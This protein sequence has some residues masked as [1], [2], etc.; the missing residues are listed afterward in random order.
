M[1]YDTFCFFNELELLEVRLNELDK[2]VDR[3]VLVEAKRSFSNHPK[4]LIYEDNK[5][6]FE[7]FNDRIIHIV[8]E[9]FPEPKDSWDT[10]TYQKNCIGS[11]LKNCQPDDLILF[12]DIDEIPRATKVLEA[13]KIL[14]ELRTPIWD[15]FRP[16]VLRVCNLHLPRRLLRKHHPRVVKFE[17][18][19]YYYYLNG[20]LAD[21]PTTYGTRMLQYKDITSVSEARYTGREIVTDAGWHF[22]FMGGA[23]RIKYKIASFSHQEINTPENTDVQ[24]I[25]EVLKNGQAPIHESTELHIKEMDDTYP[26]YVLDNLEK[27][28][29][30]IRKLS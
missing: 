16:I 14:N 5:A 4:S 12:S 24:R 29:S 17:Q 15:V 20:V 26:Q 8:V 18:D 27:F 10:Y 6:R 25:D 7:R 9:E 23:E 2:V 13:A 22:T 21:Y 3:F 1:I 30:W 19:A 11:A 28:D